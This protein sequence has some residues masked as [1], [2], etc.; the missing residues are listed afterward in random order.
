MEP[1]FGDADKTLAEALRGSV[2]NQSKWPG[3]AEIIIEP[4][5]FTLRNYCH[6]RTM[7]RPIGINA[8]N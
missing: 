7:E 4:N 2:V 3:N 6:R 1:E 8:S 5:I